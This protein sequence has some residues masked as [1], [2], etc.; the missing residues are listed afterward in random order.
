MMIMRKMVKVVSA[1]KRLEKKEK[2]KQKQK[3]NDNDCN[4]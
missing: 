2:K 1:Q 3:E 4:E